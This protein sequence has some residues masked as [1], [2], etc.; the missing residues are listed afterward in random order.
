[1]LVFQDLQHLAHWLFPGYTP[2][3]SVGLF[4]KEMF[5]WLLI[6]EARLAAV[7][8]HTAQHLVKHALSGP[9]S[10]GRTIILVTH[11]ITLCLPVASYLV[12]LSDGKIVHAGTIEDLR[13]RNLLQ[14]VV[15]VEDHP[16]SPVNKRC[17]V[18]EVNE[19]DLVNGTN[20]IA[21]Q[22]Q[23]MSNG[24]LVEAEAR[25]EGRVSVHSYLTYFRAAGLVS[26]VA[27]LWL[28]LQM[29][30]IGIGVQV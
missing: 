4:L 7:D 21:K 20:G 27:S 26:W 28:L 22:K 19:A 16:Q 30:L 17:E 29:R 5:I 9:L 12:E 2:R 18:P 1:M 11:H 15:E 13:D 8:M 25:A 6:A 23:P 10:A 24:K 14:K 3:R